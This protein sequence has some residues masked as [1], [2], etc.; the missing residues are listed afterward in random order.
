LIRQRPD[1][2]IGKQGKTA[3]AIRTLLNAVAGK[4]RKKYM[5]EIV[6]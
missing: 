5:L 3:N 1:K 4:V 2:V 6:D